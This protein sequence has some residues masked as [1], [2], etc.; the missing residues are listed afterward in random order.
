MSQGNVND[1][2]P[3]RPVRPKAYLQPNVQSSS[4]GSEEVQ[5]EEGPDDE[6]A[7]ADHSREVPEQSAGERVKRP[8]KGP[9]AD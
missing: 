2:A 3:E 8:P 1:P 7:A 9:T 4:R 5:V 6:E